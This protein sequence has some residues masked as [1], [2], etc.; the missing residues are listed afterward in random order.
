RAK[1]NKIQ[2]FYSASG[3]FTF[4]GFDSNSYVMIHL[5][6]VTNGKHL[7][8][9]PGILDGSGFYEGYCQIPH[10]CETIRLILHVATDSTDPW[11]LAVKKFQ[12][13][14]APNEF[15]KADSDWQ[16]YTPT[17]QG[18][19]TVS[20]VAFKY[21]KNGPNLEIEGVFTTGTPTATEA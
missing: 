12:I 21:R 16:T 1:D 17:F 8:P 10:D 13:D 15:V 5:Y 9:Y 6:D 11:V 14:I 4:G 3:D 20:N 2:F 7:N 18:F 19:G